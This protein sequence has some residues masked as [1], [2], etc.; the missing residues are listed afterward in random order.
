VSAGVPSRAAGDL[1]R[2]LSLSDAIALG[3]L[4]VAC[5]AVLVTVWMRRVSVRALRL[6]EQQEARRAA[7]LDVTV[8]RLVSWRPSAGTRWICTRLLAVNPTDRDAT[9]VS[10]D[11][12]VAYAARGVETV[13]VQVPHGTRD[14]AAPPAW[15]PGVAPSEVPAALPANGAFAGWLVFQIGRVVPDGAVQRFDL[16]LR[17]SRGLVE[18]VQLWAPEELA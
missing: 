2:D 6:S 15:P 8:E 7:V 18:T 9:L 16:A 13:V 3:S 17:D 11:L 1:A 14:A 4:A 10:A 5:L 12:R